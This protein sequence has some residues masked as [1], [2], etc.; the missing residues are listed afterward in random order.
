MPAWSDK[1]G[2]TLKK[3][4]SP[5]RDAYKRV[6]RWQNEETRE[7]RSGSWYCVLMRVIILLQK[8]Y[9]V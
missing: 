4:S 1:Y 7:P 5:F 2:I 6:L 3:E 8:K 9:Y